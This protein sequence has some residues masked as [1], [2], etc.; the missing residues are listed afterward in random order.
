[1]SLNGLKAV[2]PQPMSL[3]GINCLPAALNLQPFDSRVSAV[4]KLNGR[5]VSWMFQE[6]KF[7]CSMV[8]SLLARGYFQQLFHIRVVLVIAL[9]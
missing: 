9:K 2:K 6:A 4:V 8:A 7:K 3:V 1:M 5:I